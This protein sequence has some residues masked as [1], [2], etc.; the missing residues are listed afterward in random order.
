MSSLVDIEAVPGVLAVL[1]TQLYFVTVHGP[2]SK[3][4]KTKVLSDNAFANSELK[5]CASKQNWCLARDPQSYTKF[6]QHLIPSFLTKVEGNRCIP[7]TSVT[8][9]KKK[10]HHK[11][12][13]NTKIKYAIPILFPLLSQKH[14]YEGF[15]LSEALFFFFICIGLFFLHGNIFSLISI[16]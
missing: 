12:T 9:K 2:I 10:G 5:A 4:V 1:P 14:S 3:P 8:L 7:F 6:F 15:K 13:Q 16:F 11:N